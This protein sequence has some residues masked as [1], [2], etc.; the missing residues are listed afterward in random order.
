M[1]TLHRLC[2][3]IFVLSPWTSSTA[4]S[5]R[6]HGVAMT[7]TVQSVDEASRRIVFA[8]D[9]GPIRAL[10]WIR[11]ARFCHQGGESSPA[12]LKP[13]MRARVNFHNPLF[14]SDYISRVILPYPSRE[15]GAKTAK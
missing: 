4:A 10:R 12:L 5:V 13:G 9:G 14:G 7:G 1:K 15:A 11:W 6:P 3:F 2:F 8:Q